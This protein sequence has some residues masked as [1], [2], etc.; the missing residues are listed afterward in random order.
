MMNIIMKEKFDVP[1]EDDFEYLTI[2][3]AD[4]IV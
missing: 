3:S 2:I 4:F 1:I